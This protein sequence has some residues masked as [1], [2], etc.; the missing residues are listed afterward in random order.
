MKCFSYL[1]SNRPLLQV[2]KM[3]CAEGREKGT[4]LFRVT[5]EAGLDFDVLID[6]CFGIGDLRLH[7]QMISYASE[8]G[9][10]HPTYYNA[11]GY[12]WL[13]SFGGGFLVTCGLDQVGEPFQSEAEQAGLHGRVDNI[14]AEQVSH[15]VFEKDG[16]LWAELSGT[17][18]Q[19]KH[20]GEHL[21]LRRNIRLRHDAR[22]IWMSDEITN[23]GGE[24]QPFMLLYHINF[25][26]PFLRPDALVELPSAAVQGWK[27]ASKEREDQ[28]R[29]VPEIEAEPLD[30][31]WL[32]KVIPDAEGRGGVCVKNGSRAVHILYPVEELPVL[33][34]W[35]LIKEHNYVLAIE[36][37][38]SHLLG[39]QWERENGTLRTLAPGEKKTI[40]ME[41]EFE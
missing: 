8:T 4:E 19:A 20:Q 7:G 22:K 13:R 5:N 28:W 1:S 34:Q 11:S 40:A 23:C 37:T 2:R 36:P 3:V 26:F 35:E 29:R 9:I 15:R 39:R 24:S 33:A 30:M 32:H 14:P 6:R 21:Q 31:L 17:V 27:P 12:E 25:G 38:N 41:F 18:V 16:S 10:V